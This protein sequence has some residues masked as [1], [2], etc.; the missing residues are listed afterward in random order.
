MKHVL[1][2]L[3]LVLP[4]LTFAQHSLSENNPKDETEVPQVDMSVQ[5]YSLR[6]LIGT[7]ELFAKNH[8]DV[9]RN[10]AEM[11]FSGVEAASYEDGQFSGLSP[12]SFRQ[13][14]EKAGLKI[15]SSH[16][17]HPL[18]EEELKSGNYSASLAW[19]DKCIAAH[20]EADITTLVMSWSQPL[21]DIHQIRVMS[22]FLNDIGQHCQAAGIRFGYHSHSHEF[23]KVDETTMMD[24]FIWNTDPENVFFEMDVYWAVVAGV[25]PVEYMKKYPGRF[26][27]L[28]IKDKYEI[29]QSGMVGFEPI[30]RNMPIA[31]TEGFVVEMEYASTPDILKGLRESALYLRH[32][33]YTK[34]RYAPVN[35]NATPEAR[36]LLQRLYKTVEEGKIIS[37]LHH[38]Q[39]QMPN[40]RRDLNRIEDAS[41]KQPL[42]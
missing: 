38:N 37:G 34:K 18:S 41:G 24:E 15:I 11:G 19:W 14:I 40:Y 22:Q 27:L 20:K 13:A 36:A 32:A 21:N 33:P 29:G 16:A 2:I 42:I 4:M 3:A 26:G 12:L 35:T 28:H 6:S 30:F 7:P 1:I 17:T 25:S 5:L 10:V 39:L 23:K 31:G 8:E 9:L